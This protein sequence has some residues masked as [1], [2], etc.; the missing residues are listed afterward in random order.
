MN[1]EL[2]VQMIDF[3]N[4]EVHTLETHTF[5]SK[6][7]HAIFTLL[8]FSCGCRTGSTNC[9]HNKVAPVCVRAGGVRIKDVCVTLANNMVHFDDA[10]R[11]LLSILQGR[12]S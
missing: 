3:L 6:V 12:W 1:L 8:S 10:S 9:T 11:A 7:Q 2:W 5:T 4:L